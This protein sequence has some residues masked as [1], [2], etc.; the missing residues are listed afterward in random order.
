MAGVSGQN[1]GLIARA[2]K[3]QNAVWESCDKK[4]FQQN[5]VTYGV[6]IGSRNLERT[7]QN[8][9]FNMTA[10]EMLTKKPTLLYFVLLLKHK[11]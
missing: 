3:S 9:G 5:T 11:K 10:L 2:K 7:N 4:S 6:V 8:D 1:Q